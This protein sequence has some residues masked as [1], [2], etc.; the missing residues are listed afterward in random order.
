M[1]EVAII[2]L[3]VVV[4]V[5]MLERYVRTYVRIV[6]AGRAV[7]RDNYIGSMLFARSQPIYTK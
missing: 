3:V 2:V 1:V 6:A 5:L 7:R 4:V